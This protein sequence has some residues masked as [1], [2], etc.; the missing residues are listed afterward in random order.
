MPQT[1]FECAFYSPSLNS[2]L[3][4]NTLEPTCQC[5]AQCAALRYSLDFLNFFTCYDFDSFRSK[6][7]LLKPEAGHHQLK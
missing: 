2:C 3:D 1:H 5:K 4:S 7:V 6:Q